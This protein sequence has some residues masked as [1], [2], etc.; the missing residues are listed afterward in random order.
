MMFEFV[1]ENQE[2]ATIKVIGVGGAGGNA[3]NRMIEAGLGGVEFVAV[4]TDAQALRG[5]RAH[6]ALQIGCR[7]TRGLG[8]GGDPRIG[9]RAIEEDEETYSD[10]L[11][12]SDMV[13]IT[14][15]M[16]GGTGTGA[17]PVAARIARELGILTVGI[18]T[19]PF[20]FEGAVR[21]Q[22][23]E[24]G[25]AAL[26]ESVDTL[27]VIPNQRLLEI[28]PPSTSVKEAFRIAD[29]VLYEA[30]RGIY[31]IISRPN[32]VNLDFAD[33]RTVMKDMG[34]ALMGTG[35]AEGEGRAE[36]AARAA[37]SSPLLEDV[38][39]HGAKGVLVNLLGA[40]IGIAEISEAMSLIQDAAGSQAHIIFG[41]GTDESL[42][43]TMQVTVIA[44]GFQSR[45]G[46]STPF[47]ERAFLPEEPPVPARETE[48]AT[49]SMPAP[50][51]P[52]EQPAAAV[53]AAPEGPGELDG[54]D[55]PDFLL[56]AAE[57]RAAAVVGGEDEFIPESEERL[58]SRFLSPVTVQELPG[59][60]S[61]PL[62]PQPRSTGGFRSDAFMEDLSIP[63]YTRKYM[64]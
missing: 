52:A 60:G 31:E 26:K 40:E 15:G 32:H 58:I 41:Y 20:L 43:D 57:H 33:V 3:V 25:V 13:F 38:E 1:E 34:V 55:E 16:G 2:Q 9:R 59:R 4:N 45:I 62:P 37:I 30:T 27:I 56:P 14:A 22:Q 29:N 28:V 19:K 21:L 39:I 23:A 64:D 12:G 51:T 42:G 35:R 49:A 61:P 8:S 10:S 46:W 18:V 63:A 7:L 17:A 44:T 53:R 50:A 48:T 24:E 54:T 5:S 36:A 11:R 47:R 6:H